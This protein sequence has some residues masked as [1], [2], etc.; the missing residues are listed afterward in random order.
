MKIVITCLLCWISCSVMAQ[1]VPSHTKALVG[2]PVA[3]PVDTTVSNKP[4]R[5]ICVRPLPEIYQKIYIERPLVLIDEKVVGWKKAMRLD[6]NRIDSF[7]TMTTKDAMMLYG[8]KGKN[9]VVN[10]TTKTTHTP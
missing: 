5:L 8:K 10:I 6:P 9:G 4:I 7:T 3:V 1:E 2:W